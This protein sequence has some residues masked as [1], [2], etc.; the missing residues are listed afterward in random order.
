MLRGSPVYGV[1]FLFKYIGEKPSSTPRDG[2]FDS[3]APEN[4]FFAA[5]TIQN[6]CGTQALLSVLLNK[7]HEGVELG[8]T[9]TL[10]KDFTQGFPAELRGES[11]SNDPTIREVHN[12]FA[13]ASPFSLDPSLR[14]PVDPNDS[15]LYHFIA[16]LPHNNTL[17]EL[18]GLQPHPISHG[19]LSPPA[20][21]TQASD[22]FARQVVE[23]IQRRIGR[24]GEG[25]IR[26]NLLACCRDLRLRAQEMGDM[27]LLERERA[28]RRNWAWENALRRHN[29]VGLIGEVAKGVAADKVKNGTWDEWLKG[30]K[31]RAEERRKKGR[32][33][34]EMDLDG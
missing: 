25:E 1:I 2:K 24:Y 8:P 27:A 13:R 16:Y 12:S 29:F 30:A 6:A 32:G 21:S 15:D 5:Q 3:E 34:D 9:L 22:Q 10:F 31:E 28:K 11:L 7:D 4:M 33:G 14:P 18:D 20:S 23:V 19:P 17:Y 26:F